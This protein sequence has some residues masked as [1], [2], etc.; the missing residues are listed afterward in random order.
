MLKVTDFHMKSIHNGFI[1]FDFSILDPSTH[2]LNSFHPSVSP[3]HYQKSLHFQLLWKEILINRFTD[4][5]I[6]LGIL[7]FKY[8][9]IS[10]EYCIGRRQFRGFTIIVS[11]NSSTYSNPAKL[12]HVFDYSYGILISNIIKKAIHSFRSTIFQSIL[13]RYLKF[14]KTKN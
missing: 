14:W 4:S 8:S 11:G 5:D 2:L 1:N 7:Y 6:P 9:Y 12:I 13:S 3:S 10:N